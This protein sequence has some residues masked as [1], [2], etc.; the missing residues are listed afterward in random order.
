VIV[1]TTRDKAFGGGGG[2]FPIGCCVHNT[3]GTVKFGHFKVPVDHC[4]DWLTIMN[5]PGGDI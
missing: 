5:G 1:P 2:G 3:L 4:F